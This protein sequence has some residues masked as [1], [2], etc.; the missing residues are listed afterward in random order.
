LPEISQ[1]LDRVRAEAC[2]P[3]YD[4]LMMLEARRRTFE[5]ISRLS[6]EI[7]PGMTEE[8]GVALTR[9]VLSEAGMARGWHGIN[10]RFGVNTLN[11]FHVKSKPGVVLGKDDVYFIDIG[12]IWRDW[13][14]DGG[15][16]FATGSDPEFNRIAHDVKAVFAAVQAR[17]KQDRLTGEALYRV[18]VEESE[19]RGWLLNLDMSG[20]RLSE[21]PHAAH[22][23]GA[24]ADAPFTPSPGLWMLEIQLRHPTRPFGAFYEDLLLDDSG[25]A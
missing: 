24:L 25:D 17:W 7:V 18:A 20:H 8:E 10:V 21:F 6:S 2:G 19:R 9:R 5:V 22:H 16:T 15:D 12:P 11:A 1:P 4:R 13:E 23:K 3:R 14:G